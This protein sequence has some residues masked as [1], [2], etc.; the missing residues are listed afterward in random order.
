METELKEI[1]KNN[2]L[3]SDDVCGMLHISRQQVSNLVRRG[4]LKP[5]KENRGGNLYWKPDILELIQKRSHIRENAYTHEILGDST[6]SAIRMYKDLNLAQ[7]NIRKIEIYYDEQNAIYDGFY[8]VDDRYIPNTLCAMSAPTFVIELFDGT[9]FWFRGLNCGYL[10]TGPH[11]SED[12]LL[13]L[14]I[15]TRKGQL[16]E[17]FCA[18]KIRLTNEDN[19]WDMEC[20]PRNDSEESVR[21]RYSTRNYIY[22]G[23]HVLAQHGYDSASY[24]LL[25]E[26]ESP[27]T[28]VKAYADF[29]KDPVQIL[30]LS[31]EE[32]LSSG[33]FGMDYG[34]MVLYQLIIRDF[35]GKELWLAYPVDLK[36]MQKQPK[37]MDL[38]TGLGMNFETEKLPKRIFNWLQTEP[39]YT[40]KVAVKSL[41]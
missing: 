27:L 37:I 9:Q 35:S 31:R 18:G 29:I 30:F 4:S 5:L 19:R 39:H 33:H 21:A 10:G 2:V 24:L 8:C 28:Y 13:D 12:V 11:G 40:T 17:L 38:L 6:N 15:I 14:H 20:D 16:E 25:D 22:N 32:A 23:T 3:T 36:P 34:Q 41:Q 1:V 7:E 26:R